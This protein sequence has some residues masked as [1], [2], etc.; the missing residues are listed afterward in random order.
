MAFAVEQQAVSCAAFELGAGGFSDRLAGAVLDGHDDFYS[1]QTHFFGAETGEADCSFCG[2]TFAGAWRFYPVA[3]V[4]DRVPIDLVDAATA[5]KF[6]ATFTEDTEVVG[7][8]V[9]PVRCDGFQP[10]CGIPLLIVRMTPGKEFEDLCDGFPGGLVQ[11][12]FIAGFVTAYQKAFCFK[13]MRD[14]CRQIQ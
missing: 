2:D 10:V 3:K 7:G 8:A 12:F 6:I 14:W 5:V 11:H 1:L 9:F 4:S 13:G